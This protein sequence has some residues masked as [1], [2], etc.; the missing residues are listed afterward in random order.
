MTLLGYDT[1]R[2]VAFIATRIN[3][4][5]SEVS[6]TMSTYL[7]EEEDLAAVTIVLPVVVRSQFQNIASGASCGEVAITQLVPNEFVSA[8][9]D[10]D[11]R[12]PSFT[13]LKYLHSY[14]FL[15]DTLG[16]RTKVLRVG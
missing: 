10:G 7:G 4:L 14:G 6:R 13:D 9:N 5:P 11:A 15:D 1:A 3:T 16:R 12:E 2:L 8:A